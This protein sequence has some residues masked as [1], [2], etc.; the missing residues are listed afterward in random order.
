MDHIDAFSEVM[1]LLLSGCFEENTEI[2]TRDGIKKIRDIT[3]YDYIL[4]YDT[5][6]KVYSWVNPFV[7]LPTPSET[8]DKI[9]LTFEDGSTVKCT[10][11]HKLLVRGKGW[12]EAKDLTE[13][14]D[15]E[16][17]I[18]TDQP[19]ETVTYTEDQLKAEY[20]QFFK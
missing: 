18:K 19:I 1:F 10:S 16:S 8:K 13:D 11:D 2:I 5:E 20:P 4:T 7:V 17:F 3:V 12:V 6:Q 15:V 9:E 14:D